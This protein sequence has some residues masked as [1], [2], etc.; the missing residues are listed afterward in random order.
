[1]SEVEDILPSSA[2]K[3]GVDKYGRRIDYLR[4]SVTDRCNFRCVYC[5]PEE[6]VK[7]KRHED[8]LTLEEIGSFVKQAVK[9]GIRRVRVT[10]GEP[11]VRLGISDLIRDIKSNPEIEEVSLTTNGALL[12]KM[13]KELKEA[14]LDRVNISLDTLDPEIFA[15]VTRRGKLKDVLDGIEAAFEEGFDPVK[16][17]VVAVRSIMNDPLEFV[18]MTLERDIHVRF[19]EYMPIGHEYGMQDQGWT[20]NESMTSEELRE[21]IAVAARDAGLGEMERIPQ[22]KAPAG[23][24]PAQYYRFEGAVGTIGFISPLS[25][26]FCGAC[27][28]LRLTADGKIRPCLF[29]DVEYDVSQ[30]L[31]AGDLEA[32]EATIMRALDEK[33]ENHALRKGTQ[34][35]MSQIGG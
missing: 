29:S 15:R 8:I 19:I 25:N 16:I 12:R 22:S 14:G 23:A 34:R 21:M 1:M 13:A 32:V 28:R 17:N 20:Q 18:R 11:L 7:G 33:P 6:G 35:E 30:D 3:L 2:R 10:G 4:V 9:H 27:N 26:H 5:M 24:G 31:R